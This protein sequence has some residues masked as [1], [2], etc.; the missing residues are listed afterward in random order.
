M[1]E[2]PHGATRRTR[3]T[4]YSSKA[5]VRRRQV[6][7]GH[8]R[9]THRDRKGVALRQQAENAA[10]LPSLSGSRCA[11]FRRLASSPSTT[12]RIAPSSRR[13]SGFGW[14][15]RRRRDLPVVTC[16]IHARARVDR[17]R[18]GAPSDHGPSPTTT[19]KIRSRPWHPAA[20]S[21][22]PRRGSKM[23]AQSFHRL[24]CVR[25]SGASSR[26]DRHHG[27]GATA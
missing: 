19:L 3:T 9:G 10:A 16:G 2:V 7:K 24:S 26:T 1:T 12:I 15:A 11:G 23:K 27:K 22:T 4:R 5:A 17:R 13:C 20:R 8:M 25:R 21:S 6:D 18:C 14:T